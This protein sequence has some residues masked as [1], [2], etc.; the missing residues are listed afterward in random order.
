MMMMDEVLDSLS[1]SCFGAL[2][3]AFASV[4]AGGGAAASA[5]SAV[6]AASGA[7]AASDGAAGA[8]LLCAS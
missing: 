6:V 7:A 4:P 3:A 2:G 8:A 1:Q 5:A